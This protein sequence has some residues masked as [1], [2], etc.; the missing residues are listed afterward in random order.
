VPRAKTFYTALFGWKINPFP[1]S[2]PGEHEYID[3]GGTDASPEHAIM[4]YFGVPSVTK[5]IAKIAK[6]GGAVCEPKTAV[7][8]A[9]YLAVCKDTENNTF[10]VWERNPKA[11]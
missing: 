5:F 8:G 3:T 2:P 6:L 10:A 11:K 1:N 9:G 4:T 7:P